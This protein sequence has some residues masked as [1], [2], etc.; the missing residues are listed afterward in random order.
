MLCLSLM[1]LCGVSRYLK[2]KLD[3]KMYEIRLLIYMA[4]SDSREQKQEVLGSALV[5]LVPSL[6]TEHLA[7]SSLPSSPAN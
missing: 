7:T 2:V 4:G 3:V 1:S 5:S 6:S